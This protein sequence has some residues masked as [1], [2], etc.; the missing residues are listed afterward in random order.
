MMIIIIMMMMMTMLVIDLM[1]VVA[2]VGPSGSGKSTIINLLLRFY[3]P[4][5]GQVMMMIIM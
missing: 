1:Q 5:E 2:L 3:D 4:T